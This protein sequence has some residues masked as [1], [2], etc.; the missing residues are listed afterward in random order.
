MMYVETLDELKAALKRMKREDVG[1]MHYDSYADLF[2][3]GK[4]DKGARAKAIAF[5]NANGCRIEFR[6]MDP[7]VMFIKSV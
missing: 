4:T 6:P 1:H 3:P 7:Q 5:A 2:P